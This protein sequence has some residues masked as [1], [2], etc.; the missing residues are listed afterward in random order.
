MHNLL[1]LPLF[2]IVRRLTVKIGKNIML[3]AMLT[4]TAITASIAISQPGGPALPQTKQK[5]CNA[6]L[7]FDVR[8][9]HEDK[10]VN[11]C[12]TY[13]GNVILIVNTASRCAFTDQYEGLEALYSQYQPHG[14]VVLGFPS[15][16][17]GNQD[18]GSEKQIKDFCR[19]TYGV[20]FP[21]FQKSR[22]KKNAADPLF[23]QLGEQAGYPRWNFY[24]YL[25]DRNGNLVDSYSSFTSPSDKKLV[26]K[27][28]TLL[29]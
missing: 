6:N 24:K 22:V 28:E 10:V 19:L 11:L 26:G 13:Q 3:L 9:L 18:P 23:V 2:K 15:N 17:F 29:F 12:D 27:I 7:N 25:I 5:N 16:D 4:V 14:L 21:M 8:L 1:H 20:Q